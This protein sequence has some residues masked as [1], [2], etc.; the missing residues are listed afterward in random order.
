MDTNI[1]V[2]LAVA[3]LLTFLYISKLRSKVE[4]PENPYLVD[5][6]TAKEFAAGSVPGAINIPLDQIEARRSELKGKENLVLFC[7]SG[8]RSGQAKGIL[9]KN[10]FTNVVNGGGWSGVKKRMEK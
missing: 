6:R 4:I 8:M 3:G 5:V 9:E 2:F 1:L 7:R 10:G